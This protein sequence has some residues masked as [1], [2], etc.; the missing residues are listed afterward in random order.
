MALV[1]GPPGTGKSEV[2]KWLRDFFEEALG[3]QHEE[4][5]LCVAF[6]N[7][8]AAMI[9]GTTFHS[10][11]DLPKPGENR[12]RKLEH[13]DVDNLY[14]R[15]AALRWIL[16][17][18]ISMV[19]HALLGEFEANITSAARQTRHAKRADGSLRLFGGYNVVAFGDWWQLPPIPDAGALFL[20]PPP[21][22]A[23]DDK[24]ERAR[25][26]HEMF[27][28]RGVDSINFLAELTIQKRQDDQWFSEVLLQCRSGHLANEDYYFLMGLPTKRCGS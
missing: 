21:D 10:G 11:G 14:V 20:P 26:V 13:S 18:E 23:K 19:S 4:Q 5:F 1:H 12:D 2:L 24:F 27:W 7:R 9:G 15:N 25:R 8:M 3:W 17:D 28:H 6:Q 22:A 16:I